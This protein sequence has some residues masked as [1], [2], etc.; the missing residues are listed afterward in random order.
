MVGMDKVGEMGEVGEMD[1]SGG[2]SQ[3]DECR[4]LKGHSW[5][6]ELLAKSPWQLF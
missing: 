4:S 3:F 6:I 2:L 5:A 1:Y